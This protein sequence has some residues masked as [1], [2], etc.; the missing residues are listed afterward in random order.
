MS[1]VRRSLYYSLADNYFS[2]AL[3]FVTTVIV[4]R[5]LTPND[6]GVFVVAAGLAAIASTFRDFGI[7]EYL[8]QTVEIT[9]EKI[10]SAFTV[11]LVVSWL[12]ALL[13]YLASHWMD[14]FYRSAGVGEV[15][16]LQAI[17]FLLIP[18]GALTMAWFRRALNYVPLLVIGMLSNATAF[19]VAI[20]CAYQG[21]GYM[22]L[23]WSSIA[24]VAVTV[25]ASVLLRPAG[26]PWMPSFAEFRSVVDF[27]KH[28]VAIY[29]VG[30]IGRSAPDAMIGRAMD[31]TSVAFFSRSFGL[32]DL[33][34]RMVFKAVLPICLPY[35][36]QQRREGHGVVQG[37]MKAVVLL[38]GLGWPFFVV[39][40][41]LAPSLIH[42]LYGEQWD[43]AAALTP[44]LCMAAIVELSYAL[45]GE[46][47]IAQGR[48]DHSNRLQIA[49][50]GM[51]VLGLL[52][53]WP[54]GLVGATW[55]LVAA[56]VAGAMVAQWFL[57]RTIQLPWRQVLAT[58]RPSATVALSAGAPAALWAYWAEDRV[59]LT[60]YHVLFTGL[61][62]SGL[63]W[64]CAIAATNHP[65]WQEMRQ[66]WRD[67]Q[68]GH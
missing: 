48:V 30:Q 61:A 34:H 56:S 55:G 11:N 38:T 14:D 12:M 45:A 22:S 37:Y 26:L 27:G 31:L 2:I 8:I 36:S 46:V 40:G 29:F 32:I 7:A 49:V 65:I 20:Y 47:M 50:Q 28:A 57:G 15:M 51:R 25:A 67:R 53:V 6:I 10:R 19:G 17:N 59:G 41:F 16:R 5:L 43:S 35:F 66:F 4:S 18:F 39:I 60:H 42:V 44:V 3:Q 64:L 68:P 54:F 58:C 52:L 13:L 1:T 33:F 21:F 62:L 24:G 9:N 63:A 23:A